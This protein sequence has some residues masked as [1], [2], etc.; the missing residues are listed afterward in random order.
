ME[1]LM[2]AVVVILEIVA[3]IDVLRSYLPIAK[4]LLWI[5]LILIVPVLGV[6]LYFLLGKPDYQETA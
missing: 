3:M 2:L 4:K 1:F 6:I 5:T